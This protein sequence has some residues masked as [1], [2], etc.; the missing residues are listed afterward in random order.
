[1]KKLILLLLLF[2]VLFPQA[3]VWAQEYEE[4]SYDDLVNRLGKKRTQVIRNQP[5]A[6]VLDDIL[7]HAG[8]ALA[9]SSL[10]YLNNGQSSQK[11]VNGFQLSF[12]IDLFS[13][14]WSAEG[15]LRNLGGSS[16][17][18]TNSEVKSFREFNVEVM[19]RNA[20]H[21]NVFGYRM[22]F[23]FGNRYLR[24]SENIGT[25]EEYTPLLIVFTG[26]DFNINRHFGIGGELSF[27]S[28]MLPETHDKSSVD[29][30][31][32]LDTYF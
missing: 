31:V 14:N 28:S 19:Y 9:N 21:D 16:D 6:N 7:I 26:V 30:L 1:M 29:L 22:G 18:Q 13:P 32:R 23:G 11:N 3:K 17:M 25:F 20:G 27:R 5:G 15:T 12:G 8:F 2:F 10:S 24:V 4:I